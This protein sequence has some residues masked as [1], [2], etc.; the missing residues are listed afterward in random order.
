VDNAI[1]AYGKL[2]RKY[3]D[4]KGN[5]IVPYSDNVVSA[6]EFAKGRRNVNYG[7][8]S[9]YKGIQAKRTVILLFCLEGASKAPS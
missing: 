9:V 1:S 2:L 3:T 4:S 8:P 6:V 7:F 5:P